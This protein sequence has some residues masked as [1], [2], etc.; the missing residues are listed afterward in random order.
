MG[1]FW[2]G[3]RCYGYGTVQEENPPDLEHP[4]RRSV[5]E[6]QE[7]ALVLRGF[8]LFADG[9]ALKKIAATLNE[10][11]IPAPNGGG[12][13]NKRG[14]GWGHTTIRAMLRNERYLGRFAWNKSKWARV[15]G[16]KSRRQVNRPESEWITHHYPQLAII[17]T[18]VSEMSSGKLGCAGAQRGLYTAISLEFERRL[19]A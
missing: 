9:V 3:G 11:G 19:V 4:R 14:R 5:I 18:A 17:P 10:E 7:A 2:T 15:S 8:R 13:D 12:R 16:R 6:P 1:G